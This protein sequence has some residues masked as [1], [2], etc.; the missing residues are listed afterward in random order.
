MT[1][2]DNRFGFRMGMQTVPYY[3]KRR[4]PLRLLCQPIFPAESAVIAWS[5]AHTAPAGFNENVTQIRRT[6]GPRR[7]GYLRNCAD[8]A[9][10]LA[11]EHRSRQRSFS[12]NF[13]K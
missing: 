6:M 1:T 4:F 11:Q 9:S 2:P 3:P 8:D 10:G 12:G 5:Q 7:D 13:R